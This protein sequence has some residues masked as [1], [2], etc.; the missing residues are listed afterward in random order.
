M[1]QE[2]R[3]AGQFQSDYLPP[4]DRLQIVI[5]QEILDGARMQLPLI[6]EVA[7]RAQKSKPDTGQTNHFGNE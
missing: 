3:E 2:A 5:V 1:R 7:K 6:A 4:V